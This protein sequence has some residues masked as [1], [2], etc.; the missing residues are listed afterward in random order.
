[1]TRFFV[2]FAFIMLTISA[3]ARAEDCRQYPPGPFR[4]E[5]ASRQHPGL[6]AK[7]ERCR[8]EGMNMGLSISKPANVGGLR[9]YVQGCMHR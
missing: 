5:C 2:A 6:S 9:D 7:R 4:F 1:M 3:T 8:Q